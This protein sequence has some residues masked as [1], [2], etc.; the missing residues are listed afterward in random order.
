VGEGSASGQIPPVHELMDA[1]L[2]PDWVAEE[3]EEHLL[4]HIRALCEREGSPLRLISTASDGAVFLVNLEWT[5]PSV[6]AR[7]IT[8]AAYSLLGTFAESHT[9]VREQTVANA[10]DFE[11]TTGLLDLDQ[12][13]FKGHGHVVRLHITGPAV[14]SMLRRRL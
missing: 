3:P 4:P 14:E 11:I 9:H 12:P 1:M 13:P 5:R 2:R 7:H 10:I 8:S 6:T